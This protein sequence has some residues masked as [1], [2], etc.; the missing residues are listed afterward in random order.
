M[1]AGGNGNGRLPGGEPGRP[2]PS[3]HESVVT[4][5]AEAFRGFDSD[6]PADAVWDELARR[7]TQI[8]A[9]HPDELR[10][11]ALGVVD[12]D[13]EALGVF[14]AFKAVATGQLTRLADEGKLAPGLDVEW[15]ALHIVIF[16]LGTVLFRQAVDHHLP[17][18]LATAAGLE[19]WHQ[20]DTE[21]FRRGFLR[22]PV[23]R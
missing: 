14:D 5:T 8:V 19:R 1:G 11:I 16:N 18:P 17:D 22:Q 13:P 2:G 21:L 10:T 12:G 4:L 23:R 3:L 7:V 6:G 15:A 20:A 9:D